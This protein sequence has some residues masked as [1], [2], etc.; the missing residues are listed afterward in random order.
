MKPT[1]NEI[2]DK[3]LNSGI[4]KLDDTGK[5]IGVIKLEEGT[6][7]LSRKPKYTQSPSSSL[8][9]L[10]NSMAEE[11]GDYLYISKHDVIDNVKIFEA[12]QDRTIEVFKK[13]LVEVLKKY[14]FT[15]KELG[16]QYTEF[17]KKAGK[18]IK[19]KPFFGMTKE[20][21]GKKSYNEPF[22]KS[23]LVFLLMS[24][25]NLSTLFDRSSKDDLFHYISYLLDACE[26]EKGEHKKI[27]NR[28]KRGYSRHNDRID[29][30]GYTEMR[31]M[32]L[33]DYLDPIKSLSV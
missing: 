22:H 21:M 31:R 33:K 11:I 23:I 6:K 26:I 20:K 8:N 30:G 17:L 32:R 1:S 3:I 2:K 27:F 25:L 15:R 19:K 10:I 29:K 9:K 24:D 16:Q 18:V 7:I 4:F 13:D 14:H 28:I 12:Y 5:P